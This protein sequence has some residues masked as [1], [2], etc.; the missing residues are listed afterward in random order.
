M[1]YLVMLNEGEDESELTALAILRFE[2]LVYKK[3]SLQSLNKSLKLSVPEIYTIKQ[4]HPSSNEG[5]EY[6]R[7][8]A[9]R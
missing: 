6:S 3:I 2:S 7:L 4:E 9:V 5:T 1:D 8:L